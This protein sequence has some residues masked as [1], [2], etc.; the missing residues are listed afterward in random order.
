MGTRADFYVGR[1]ENAEWLGSVAYDGYPSGFWKKPYPIEWTEGEWRAWVAKLMAERDDATTPDMGWPWPWEDSRTTDYAYAF[2]ADTVWASPFGR[3]WLPLHVEAEHDEDESP[4][5][6][7]AVFPNMKN[8][9]NVTFGARS[10]VLII[11]A[12]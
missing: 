11:G 2:D 12:K 4:R 5:A 9:Q 3:S 6:K 8:Q 10:G 1:G 7:D